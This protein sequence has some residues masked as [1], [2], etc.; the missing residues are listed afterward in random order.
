MAEEEPIYDRP[1][2]FNSY[3]EL[4]RSRKGLDGA[5][6]WPTLR[7]MVGSLDGQAVLDAGAQD[8]QAIDGAPGICVSLQHLRL[9][10]LEGRASLG[11]LL[12]LGIRDLLER[13][14][15]DAAG[16]RH[17]DYVEGSKLRELRA[18]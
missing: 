14:G 18:L 15:E 5:P 7:N 16:R 11:E 1:S 9:F 2:F 10:R 13:L 6:E 12:E 8:F 17:L 3:L 4:P